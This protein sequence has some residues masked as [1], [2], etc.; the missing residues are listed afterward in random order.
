MKSSRRD[1]IKTN[2]A[3][4][5][6]LGSVSARGLN[7]AK[8][9]R[10]IAMPTP[11][12]KTLMALFGLKYPIFEAPH[13]RATGPELAIA[14]SNAGAMGALALAGRSVE[15][16]RTWVSKVR[17]TTKGRTNSFRAFRKFGARIGFRTSW[18]PSVFRVLSAPTMGECGGV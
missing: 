17:T 4:G 12:A 8:S 11:R 7:A 16:V 9:Q 2:A 10:L 5:T 3:A 15:E 6:L 18:S 1:F 13:G 14:V